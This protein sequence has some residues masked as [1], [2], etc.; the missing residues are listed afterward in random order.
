MKPLR[1]LSFASVTPPRSIPGPPMR[2]L[3]DTSLSCASRASSSAVRLGG[4][5][6]SRPRPR[7]LGA[8]GDILSASMRSGSTVMHGV[9]CR[10]CASLRYASESCES[11]FGS[12]RSFLSSQPFHPPVNYLPYQRDQRS[13]HRL[14]A[15]TADLCG[16]AGCDHASCSLG[17]MNE[18]DGAQFSCWSLDRSGSPPCRNHPISTPE[19]CAPSPCGVLCK[20]AF[21]AS[22]DYVDRL[23]NSATCIC[24][25]GTA[26][27]GSQHWAIV[28]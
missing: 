13:A 4:R 14:A 12:V 3:S 6:R 27:N 25:T 19:C 11:T 1:R 18:A 23:G 21:G 10:P 22:L 8:C 5:P 20:H 17:R 16:L 26:E 15:T 24:T 2:F 28:N 7:P 9:T